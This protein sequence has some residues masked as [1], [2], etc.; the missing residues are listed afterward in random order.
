MKSYKN[1]LYGQNK[2]KMKKLTKEEKITL[3]KELRKEGWIGD[4]SDESLIRLAEKVL[5]YQLKK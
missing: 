1:M 5:E 3:I 2:G 4:L